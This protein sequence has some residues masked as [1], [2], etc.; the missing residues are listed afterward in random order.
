M[1]VC[2]KLGGN[3]KMQLQT[4]KKQV[5]VSIIYPSAHLMPHGLKGFENLS[6]QCDTSINWGVGG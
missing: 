6:D 2:A 3:H 4:S 1:Y 5:D